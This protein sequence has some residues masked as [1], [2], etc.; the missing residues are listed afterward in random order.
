MRQGIITALIVAAATF[1]APAAARPFHSALNNHDLKFDYQWPAEAAAIPAL[2][3]RFHADMDKALTNAKASARDDVKLA[4]EQKRNFNQ[5]YYSLKWTA[6]GQSPRLL[7]L[8]S[9]NSLF[10]G[11]AHPMTTYGALLWDRREN[12]AIGLGAVFAR[13]GDLTAVTHS[14]YCKALDAERAKRRQGMKMDLAEFNACPKYS[15]LAISPF[16]TDKDGKFNGLRFVASPY[17]AGPYAEGE[18]AITLPV[19]LKL[20]AALRPDYRSSFELYRQ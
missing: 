18:Y 12:R 3:H 9:E 11:G 15:D 19:T 10:E 14:A 8:E 13:S 5:H 2:D 4:R 6:V 7:S 20:L 17:V 16:D 1:A